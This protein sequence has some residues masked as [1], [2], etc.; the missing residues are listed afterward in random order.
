MVQMP[1]VDGP[2]QAEQLLQV[3]SGIA[4]GLI[5]THDVNQTVSLN[6][7]CIKTSQHQDCQVHPGF[8]W[9]RKKKMWWVDGALTEKL[10][11]W[12]EEDCQAHQEE[13][14][15]LGQCHVNMEGNELLDIKEDTAKNLSESGSKDDNDNLVE[16]RELKV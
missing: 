10:C 7:L 4:A 14:R 3:T 16:I 9:D 1:W 11:I 6:E 8:R 15:K 12:E 2:S 13:L 5:K